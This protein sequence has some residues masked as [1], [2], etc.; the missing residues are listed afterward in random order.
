[1]A[2]AVDIRVHQAVTE[3]RHSVH[4]TQMVVLVVVQQ[5]VLDLPSTAE[6]VVHMVMMVVL[7]LPVVHIVVVEAVVPVVLV[8]VEHPPQVVMVVLEFEYLQLSAIPQQQ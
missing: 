4:S 8:L 5:V 7:V 3:K 6:A 1:M 2:L